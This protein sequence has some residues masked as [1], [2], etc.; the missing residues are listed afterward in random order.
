[1]IFSIAEFGLPLRD[2]SAQASQNPARAAD[3]EQ[4]EE[5]LLPSLVGMRP[6]EKG[7]SESHSPEDRFAKKNLRRNI[8]AGHEYAGGGA[9]LLAERSQAPE[10][11]RS[12]LRGHAL[13]VVDLTKA[14]QLHVF[15]I[16]CSEQH[17]YLSKAVYFPVIGGHIKLQA[18]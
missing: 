11:A 10:T 18:T 12:S 14:K 7:G 5:R 1:M 4:D 13:G 9:G 2:E 8:R 15:P 6:G 3:S 16:A 17:R